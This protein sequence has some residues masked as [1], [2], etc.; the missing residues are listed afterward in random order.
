MD[1]FTKSESDYIKKIDDSR[2]ATISPK[3]WP[4]V[5][6]IIHA[7]DGKCFYTA[8][9]FGTQKAKNIESNNRVAL[10]VDRYERTPSAVI[11]QGT[12]ELFKE[13]K[14]FSHG[15]KL[16]HER[17]AYYRAN[18]FKENEAYI[19]KITPATKKSWGIK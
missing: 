15:Y 16:L 2:L 9:D 19:V 12:A 13:G 4:Q 11:V 10:V 8:I 18:P 1:A 7:F 17:H 3:G 6:P 5:T 14:E